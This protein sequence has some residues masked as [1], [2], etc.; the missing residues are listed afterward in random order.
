MIILGLSVGALVRQATYTEPEP[1]FW[2]EQTNFDL[3][4]LPSGSQIRKVITISNRG[5]GLL[6]IDKVGSSCGCT[7]G[8]IRSH[9]VS[10]DET[11]SLE[12]LIAVPEAEGPNSSHISF[13]TNDKNSPRTVVSFA[14]ESGIVIEPTPSYVNIG[15]VAVEDLPIS[16][17]VELSPGRLADEYTFTSAKASIKSK[18]IRS[19]LTATR[20]RAHIS[21]E[22]PSDTPLGLHTTEIIVE[23]E[24]PHK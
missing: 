9:S 19:G 15:D 21:V 7:V 12:V 5:S 13:E 11:T 22:I 6:S 14:F 2:M 20:D 24:Q 17:T 8:V 18:Y 23:T 4:L 10:P 3:G 1:I 16:E